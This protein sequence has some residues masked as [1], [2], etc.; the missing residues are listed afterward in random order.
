MMEMI[1]AYLEQ[2]PPLISMMK[3][4]LLD[5][6]WDSL[7]AAVHKMIP[8]FTIMGMSTDFEKM[9]KK[10]LDFARTQQQAEDISELVL[11]LEGVC[12]QACKELEAEFNRFKNKNA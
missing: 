1:S 3:Q 6:D 4:S 5:K 9:A 11:Q 12:T 2:T 10:V 8:S 7:H